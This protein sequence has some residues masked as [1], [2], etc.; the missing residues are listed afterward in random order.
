[1]VTLYYKVAN[2]GVEPD[3]TTY[4]KRVGGNP[5]ARCIDYIWYSKGPCTNDVRYIFCTLYPLS[6]P[7]LAS[8]KST[9]TPFLWSEIG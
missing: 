3:F 4:K 8:L 5:K 6:L 2:G 9:L 1:M 7:S